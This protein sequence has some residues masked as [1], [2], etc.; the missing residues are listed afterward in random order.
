M[1]DLEDALKELKSGKCRDPDGLIREIFKE[2]VIG[3]D[4][5]KSMLIMYNK[6]KKTR[7][8]PEFMRKNKYLCNLQG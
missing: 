4:L 8:F 7:I 6:I 2:E 3:R 5:K 1:Q